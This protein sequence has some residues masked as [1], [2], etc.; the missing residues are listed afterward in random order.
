MGAG[1]ILPMAFQSGDESS[2][3]CVPQP[4]HGMFDPNGQYP[5]SV[6]GG[7]DHQSCTGWS[8]RWSGSP[9][10]RSQMRAVLSTLAVVSR[11]VDSWTAAWKT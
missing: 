4:C 10:S 6:E 3:P 11:P 9:V 7:S 5:R 2:I 8:S 1:Q